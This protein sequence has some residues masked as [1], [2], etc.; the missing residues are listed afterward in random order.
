LPVCPR[1]QVRVL[2]A[3]PPELHTSFLLPLTLDGMLALPRRRVIRYLFA[4][5]VVAAVYII[6][7][8]PKAH[9]PVSW[10]GPSLPSGSASRG[11]A[12]WPHRAK[13]V[14]HAF[15]HAYGAYEKFA[16]PHDELK[17]LSR[18]WDDKCVMFR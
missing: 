11:S 2:G 1:P 17:P 7:R 18:S 10:R 12:E 8:N 5:A 4:L 13:R 14:R 16:F 3:L 9:L 15:L 6:Y